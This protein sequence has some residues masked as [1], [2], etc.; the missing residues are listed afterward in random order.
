MTSPISVA[1]WSRLTLYVAALYAVGLLVLLRS[2]LRNRRHRPVTWVEVVPCVLLIGAGI[3]LRFLRV[4]A[5]HGGSLSPDEAWL[6]RTYVANAVDLA[7]VLAGVTD[8]THALMLDAW[9]HV[10]GLQPLSSRYF[11]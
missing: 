1:L 6:S 9:Y 2:M 4:P 10:V 11:T 8:L 7:P 5:L 3:A